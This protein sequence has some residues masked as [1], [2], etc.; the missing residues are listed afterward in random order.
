MCAQ[1]TWV[2]RVVQE[3]F[4]GTV[5][6]EK[7]KQLHCRGRAKFNGVMLPLLQT[8]TFSSLPSL[9]VFFFHIWLYLPFVSHLPPLPQYH[10]HQQ[11]H[12]HHK[13][14]NPREATISSPAQTQSSWTCAR[15]CV[16]NAEGWAHAMQAF[17]SWQK[18]VHCRVVRSLVE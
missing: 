10:K 1:C 13:H 17:V 3:L 8:S 11:Y 15:T 5:P 6:L 16:K 9:V 7:A 12:H 14:F 18:Q 2:V 4:G